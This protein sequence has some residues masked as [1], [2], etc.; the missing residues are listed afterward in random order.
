[1]KRHAALEPSIGHLKSE[2]RLECWNV[3]GCLRS[4]GKVRFGP[5]KPNQVTL[6]ASTAIGTSPWGEPH[7]G[8]T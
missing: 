3:I 2:Q 8:H 6:S 1:M 5:A 7:E 4:Y